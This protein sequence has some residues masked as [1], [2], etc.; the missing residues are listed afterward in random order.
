M[1]KWVEQM[2]MNGGPGLIIIEAEKERTT[3]VS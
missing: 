1:G 2:K 3:Q